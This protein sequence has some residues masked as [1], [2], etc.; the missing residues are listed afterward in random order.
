MFLRGKSKYL[1]MILTSC[2][3]KWLTFQPNLC[4]DGSV[5]IFTKLPVQPRR[6]CSHRASG[7]PGCK[8]CNKELTIIP[9]STTC[10]SDHLIGKKKTIFLSSFCQHDRGGFGEHVVSRLHQ[11]FIPAS[12]STLGRVGAHNQKDRGSRPDQLSVASSPI[13]IVIIPIWRN[14]VLIH[15]WRNIQKKFRRNSEEIQKKFRRNIYIVI[16]LIWRDVYFSAWQSSPWQEAAHRDIRLR[17]SVTPILVKIIL[18]QV[19]FY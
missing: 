5:H 12:D 17:W 13:Y 10:H 16:I 18:G 2:N 11:T 6:E 4:N 1:L 9:L 8:S 19:L 3:R 15:I 7:F 14:I